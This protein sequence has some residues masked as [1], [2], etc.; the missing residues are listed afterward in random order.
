MISAMNT[1]HT[2]LAQTLDIQNLPAEDQAEIFVRLGENIMKQVIIDINDRVPE[3]IREE[4]H[5]L[6]ETGSPEDVVQFLDPIIPDLD[7]VIQEASEKTIIEFKI[8]M[9]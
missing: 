4:F 1:L 6:I 9:S 3:T 8:A 7:T 2:E 5:K